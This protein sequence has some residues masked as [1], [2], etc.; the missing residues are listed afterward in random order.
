[1]FV[2]INIID[3]SM[4]IDIFIIYTALNSIENKLMRVSRSGEE[5]YTTN[6]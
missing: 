4:L 1:M 3:I 6:K 5:I 2:I